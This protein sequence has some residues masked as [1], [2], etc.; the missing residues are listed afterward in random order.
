MLKRN[1][2]RSKKS[3]RSLVVLLP[4]IGLFFAASAF[5]GGGGEHIGSVASRI[6]ESFQNIGELII[7]VAYIAGIGFAIAAI[8]KF[9]QHKDNPTQ[10]PLGT[11]IA[12]LVIGIA[13]VFLPAFFEPAGK[14]VFGDSAAD[15]A[16]GFKG[17]A[18]GK[19]PGAGGS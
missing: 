17:E 13:L 8:F 11:P 2:Q 19:L 7:A 6:T 5:A 16:G 14:T 3:L 12:M 15:M 9:K 1:M 4:I 10:I 18:A